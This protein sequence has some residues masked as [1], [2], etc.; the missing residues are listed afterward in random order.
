MFFKSIDQQL[1]D[2]HFKSLF[3]KKVYLFVHQSLFTQ[4]ST[5]NSVQYKQPSSVE[6]TQFSTNNWAGR[7]SF[8]GLLH[9]PAIVRSFQSGYQTKPETSLTTELYCSS[10]ATGR[11]IEEQRD[12]FARRG[13]EEPHARAFWLTQCERSNVD[14]SSLQ[15]R[16]L[17]QV[18][19]L[20]S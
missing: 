2:F 11:S 15:H 18:Q 16:Q 20:H 14:R 8:F 19:T 17:N 13:Y 6:T 12:Q 10:L 5:N 4:F 7:T 3:F 9:T 1:S